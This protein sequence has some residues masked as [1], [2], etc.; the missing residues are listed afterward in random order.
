MKRKFILLVGL[1]LLLS[2]QNIKGDEWEDILANMGDLP[3]LEDDGNYHTGYLYNAQV[4]YK[5]INGNNDHKLSDGEIVYFKVI[6]ANGEVIETPSDGIP[7]ANLGDWAK[8]RANEL[9]KAIFGGDVIGASQGV[10]GSQLNVITTAQSAMNIASADI[11]MNKASN[12]NMKVMKKLQKMQEKKR[13]NEKTVKQLLTSTYSTQ[14]TMDSE[15]G[16]ILNKG[17]KGRSSAGA[18][19]FRKTLNSKWTTGITI[20]YRFS[21]I[22]DN[23]NTNYKALTFIPFVKYRIYPQKQLIVDIMPFIVGSAVYAKSKAFPDGAGY[24]EYGGGFSVIPTYIFNPQFNTQLLVGYQ[25]SKKYIP[26]SA[27]PEDVKFV[28][29]AINSLK[30]DQILSMSLGLNYIP[31]PNFKI[32]WN[33][34]HIQHLQNE[35]VEGGRDKATYYTI[36]GF[37]T[38]RRFTFALG[39]KVASQIKDYRET[40][41]MASIKY[42]W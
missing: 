25:W 35:S 24:L 11:G 19:T 14:V 37:Y 30:P 18:F 8:D 28:A 33:I 10:S 21:H 5:I 3:T 7:K 9:F 22:S 23:W 41:Y 15:T 17:Y 31:L 34:L 38:F 29:D 40:D 27:V 1:S 12:Y 6:G 4:T 26:P 16:F 36:K 13:E 20:T 39:L 32:T 2:T 42:N